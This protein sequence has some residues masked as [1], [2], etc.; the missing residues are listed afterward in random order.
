[1]LASLC[2]MEACLKTASSW[3]WDI[4]GFVSDLRAFIRYTSSYDGGKRFKDGV[5]DAINYAEAKLLGK[6]VKS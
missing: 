1:M 4:S 3:P 2:T 6:F 5:L